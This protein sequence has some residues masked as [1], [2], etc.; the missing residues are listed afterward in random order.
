MD[1]ESGRYGK[2]RNSIYLELF[3]RSPKTRLMDLFLDNPFFEFSRPELIKALGMAKVTL[4]NELPALV[5][6]GMVVNTRKVGNAEL[7]KLNT[8][9]EDV[10]ALFSIIRN[11][12]LKLS[13]LEDEADGEPSAIKV[14]KTLT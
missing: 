3:G 5:K 4:Y 13:E 1:I 6:S 10:K 9:S 8:E 2:E 12:S 11:F 14:E 7:F